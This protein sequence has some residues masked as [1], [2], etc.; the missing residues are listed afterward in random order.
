[1]KKKILFYLLLTTS[2]AIG[3]VT[4]KYSNEFLNIGVDAA[5]LGMANAVVAT[6]NDVNAVYW[7]PAG[8]VDIKGYQAGLMHTEYFAGIGK[9]DYASFAMPLE[10]NSAF[11]IAII[12]FGVDDILDTTDLIDS[13]GNIDYNRVDLFTAADYALLASFAKKELFKGLDIGFN[14]KIIR[15]VIGDFAN[16]WGFGFDAGIQYSKNKWR[17]GLMASDITTTFNAWSIDEEGF[18]AIADAIPGQN[19]TL[20][21]KNELTIPKLQLGVARNF[22]LSSD[23]GLH[24]EL[25]FNMRFTETNDIISSSIVSVDPALGFELDYHKIVY[26]RGG[27]GNFQNITEFDNSTSL[28]VQPNIGLGFKYKGI[29]IDYAL[30]NIASVG[31]ALYSNVFSLKVDFD[32]FK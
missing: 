28:N 12:R 5:S 6:T 1:M 24:T 17:F 4:R 21:E 23:I 22:S 13:E 32:A 19:Q 10:N 9:Y 8:L 31:N 18:Q 16:S 27:V 3:Q 11:G 26:L 30:T 29:Q 14:A 7:N 15:R 20:P 25:D 2:I